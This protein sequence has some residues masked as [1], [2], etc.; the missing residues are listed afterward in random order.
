MATSSLRLYNFLYHRSPVPMFLY[1][2][3]SLRIRAANEAARSKYG[4]SVRELRSMTV[5][6]LH[7]CGDAPAPDGESPSGADA[8]SSSLWTHITSRG[9]LLYVEICLVPFVHRSQSLCLMSAVDI[10]GWSK[11]KLR[12]LRSEEIHRSLVEECPFGIY[13]FNLTSLRYEQANSALLQLLGYSLEDFC[14]TPSPAIYADSAD[15][16]RYQA[17]LRA[18]GRVRDFET[19]FRT[20]DGRILRVCISGY[21]G[22]D[23]ENSQ[24]FVQ[25]YVQDVTRQRELEEHL[26][27]SHRLEVVGRLA[28]GVAHDFNNITQ[29]ISLS[30]ELALLQMQLAPA[31]QSKLMDIMKQTMR[32]AEITRQLL[33]FSRRQVL[34]P[35]VVNIND[36]VRN[37]LSMIT[38]TLGVEV[39]IALKLDETVAPI[40]IDPDQFA[41]VL[42]Q[43]AENASTA[44]PQGGQLR[45]STAA[46]PESLDA[47]D[48]G[49]KNDANHDAKNDV[50]SLDAKPCVL[51]T[52]SDTGI[53]MNEKTLARIFEPFFSTKNTTLTSGLGLSTA[54][55]IISQ[56]NGCIECESTLGQGTTFRI[57][58]PLAAIS[59]GSTVPPPVKSAPPHTPPEYEGTA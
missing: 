6:D 26:R 59:P 23:P 16:Q 27:Q 46:C 7:P 55:G 8:P 13:R 56:S 12:L 21:L 14:S 53:G 58:L 18:A 51:L 34:Q 33:A 11:S 3:N 4:Y 24:E 5:R 54:H 30:C 17:E 29:S 47:N 25:C 15:H 38:R 45:I 2:C 49:V 31:L 44:M 36:C 10:S 52:V 41:I 22:A 37:S 32:A 57:Y 9:T 50:K 1:D 43:L 28:G 40:F 19:R 39:D 42:M 35:Q 20:K 48:P